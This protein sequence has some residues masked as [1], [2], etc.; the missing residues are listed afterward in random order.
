MRGRLKCQ[1]SRPL[2]ASSA[3]HSLADVMYMMPPATTGVTSSREL[4]ASGY[5]HT[6]TNEA[7]L[8]RVIRSSALNRLPLGCPWYVGQSASEVTVRRP[9]SDFRSNRTLPSSVSTWRSSSP[10]FS[11]MPSIVAPSVVWSVTRGRSAPS[12]DCSRRTNLI[13]DRDVA[14]GSAMPGMP[15]E[16]NPSRISAASS[17]S[18]RNASRLMMLGPRSPPRPSAPWHLEQN[19]SNTR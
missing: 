16:G 8:A 11:A 18:L 13:S 1:I 3:T 10:R 5:T 2:P 17:L 6:G 4:P 19:C 7:T 14:A 9:L 15:A 12:W